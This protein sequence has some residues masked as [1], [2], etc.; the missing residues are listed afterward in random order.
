[1][2]TSY[3]DHYIYQYELHIFIPLSLRFSLQFQTFSS[4]TPFYGSSYYYLIN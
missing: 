3:A 4:A 1:L 2:Y